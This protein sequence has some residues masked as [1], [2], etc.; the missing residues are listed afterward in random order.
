[1]SKNDIERLSADA[2]KDAKL[3]G[4]LKKI[5]TNVA[6]VVKFA[7]A[8]GYSFTEAELKN[9]AKSKK[10]KLSEEQLQ[11]V[12]GGGDAAV[13]AVHVAVVG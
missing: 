1:M 3:A 4:E 2:K 13:Y 8:N 7:K 5:G 12:A 6:A 9:Y 11:K 10:A